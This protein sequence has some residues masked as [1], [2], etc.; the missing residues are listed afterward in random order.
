MKI[1]SERPPNFNDIAKVFPIVKKKGGIIYT[2]EDTIYNPDDTEITK[3]LLAH[4]EVHATRQKLW[5]AEQ[6]WRIYLK[7][8]GFRFDEELMAHQKEY[9]VE[10][11]LGNRYQRRGAKKMIARKLAS[12][13]YGNMV[14]IK[15]A[16]GVLIS[17]IKCK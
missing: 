6:W 10:V 1:L 3:P 5:G 13:L 14:T 7:N 16:K 8:I 15:Q 11:E 2:F 9:E 4:E 17:I 12:P